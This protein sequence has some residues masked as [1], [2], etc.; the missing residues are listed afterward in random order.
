MCLSLGR[1]LGEF[2]LGD[3]SLKKGGS[4]ASFTKQVPGH[5]GLNYFCKSKIAHTECRISEVGVVESTTHAKS[6]A[7]ERQVSQADPH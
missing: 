1:S 6:D 3:P 4:G 2:L 5:P 7:P